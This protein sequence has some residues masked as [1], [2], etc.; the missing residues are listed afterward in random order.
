M[1]LLQEEDR[2]TNTVY[3]YTDQDSY[4]PLAKLETDLRP[5]LSE[6]DHNIPLTGQARAPDLQIIDLR[7][8]LP[9]GHRPPDDLPGTQTAAGGKDHWGALTR[10][11][12][13]TLPT[14]LYYFHTDLNGAPEALTDPDGEITWQLTAKVWGGAIHEEQTSPLS[15]QNLRFQGQ[16]LDRETGLHYNT[17]RYYDPDI[18]RFTTPDTIGLEGGLNLYQYAPNPFMWV[19]PWGWN[20]NRNSAI[21]NWVLYEIRHDGTILKV[22]IGNADDIMPTTGEYR[23]PHRSA[24]IAE[25]KWLYEGAK[26]RIIA[27]HNELT[28]G[29]MKEIEAARVR[30]LR[31]QGDELPLNRERD[32]RYRPEPKSKAKKCR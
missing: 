19:D 25:K 26:A 29:A 31:I 7:H 4:E 17:F 1:R 9:A 27:R 14:R 24:Q 12:R 16:Y 18:G 20:K 22:G 2:L 13:T 23:R 10:T 8:L 6:P 30:N 28:K 21:G 3:L 15:Q 32:R 11:N 5:L